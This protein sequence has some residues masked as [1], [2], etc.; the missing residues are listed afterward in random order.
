MFLTTNINVRISRNPDDVYEAVRST[1]PV[2]SDFLLPLDN[3]RRIQ[4]GFS[5]QP[6]NY[7]VNDAQILG[8]SNIILN[9]DGISSLENIVF[10]P[11]VKDKLFDQRDTS[12]QISNGKINFE[13]HAE[14][15]IEKGIFI[16]N[17]PN[18]G[19]WL[20][21][22]LGRLKYAPR[23]NKDIKYIFSENIDQNQLDLLQILGIEKEHIT[24]T[25]VGTSTRVE[26]L[27]IPQMPWHM[28]PND[29]VWWSPSAINY[30]RSR[31]HSGSPNTNADRRF[32]VTRKNTRW[33]RVLNEDR[34][35]EIAEQFGF[36]RVDFG[37][38]ST[39]K[40][41]KLGGETSTLISPIGAN[42]NQFMFMP[43]GT[44]LLE[45]APPMNCMN[46]T[47]RFCGAAG[48]KYR[49]II[50]TPQQSH[51]NSCIDADYHIDEKL[52]IE[53]LSNLLGRKTR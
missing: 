36:E 14:T 32:F 13:K 52:F 43:P 45:L 48:I 47:G 50:G 11:G 17:H 7:R 35:F 31:I 30:L 3:M 1:T 27:F 5:R 37:N 34:L 25:R 29:G 8:M 42:S 28:L 21:N 9:A 33:R 10:N 44:S 2:A 24:F 41:I 12:L 46:V 19:H 22:H 38:L 39:P 18:F 51:T 15:R 6:V 20:F 26:Q 53:E 40:Q 4:N 16:G 49:Q 23:T